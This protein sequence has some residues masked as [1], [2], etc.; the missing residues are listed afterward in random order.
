MFTRAWTCAVAPISYWCS[1]RQSSNSYCL[2]WTQLQKLILAAR[3]GI[4]GAIMDAPNPAFQNVLQTHRRVGMK[5]CPPFRFR[6]STIYPISK[7]V[8]RRRR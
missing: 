7:I 5:T 6:M 2:A 3:D 1:T 8:M 4:T